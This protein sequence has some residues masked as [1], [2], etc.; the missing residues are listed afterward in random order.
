M[1]VTRSQPPTDDADSVREYAD[2]SGPRTAATLRLSKDLR[3]QLRV[4][5]AQLDLSINELLTL[6]VERSTA[7]SLEERRPK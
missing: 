7:T 2:N 6:L 1:K 4:R 3:R 5:A